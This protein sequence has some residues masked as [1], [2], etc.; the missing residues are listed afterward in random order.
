MNGRDH[1]LAV[2]AAGLDPARWLVPTTG[3][4]PDSNSRNVA[5]AYTDHV[6]RAMRGSIRHLV[7][8]VDLVVVVRET[9]A[10]KLDPALD[11]AL[12]EVLEL[13]EPDDAIAWT[14]A[15]RT[16]IDDTFEG[17]TIPL[18]VVCKLT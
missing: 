14:T 17:W 11:A 1:V 9:R 6:D 13:L 7:E 18:T 15:T 16:A 4:R 12:L 2:L 8:T 10:D 3:Q 5:L